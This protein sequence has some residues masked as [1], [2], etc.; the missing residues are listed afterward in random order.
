VSTEP[1]A[2]QY[3]YIRSR[4]ELEALAKEFGRSDF[5][6]L[7]ISCHGN[8]RGFATTLDF[9]RSD[10]MANLL[11]PHLNGRRLFISS[12]LATNSTFAHSLLARSE[13]LSILGPKDTIYFDDAAIFW[14]SFYHLMFKTNPTAMHGDE[15]ESTVAKCAALV[16]NTFRFFRKRNGKI[17]EIVVPRI[18]AAS[19]RNKRD[20]N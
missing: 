13:C 6:Y 15:I 18:R 1:G 5:R 9:I 19:N 4:K 16:G 7:H 17:T 11:A 12:C 20:P 14:S 3:V 2:G 10:D 8:E